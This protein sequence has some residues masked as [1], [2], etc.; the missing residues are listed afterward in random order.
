MIR[1]AGTVRIASLSRLRE[2]VAAQRPGEGSSPSGSR[3]TRR[4]FSLLEI[5]VSTL[6]AGGVLVVALR[7]VG[8]AASSERVN[9]ER[10]RATP[11]AGALMAEVL[12]ANYREPKPPRVF[13]P[14]PGETASG[15]RALFDD[16]DDYHGWTESPPQNKDGAVLPGLIGWRRSVTVQYVS[17]DNLATAAAGDLGVKRVTVTVTR[18]GRPVFSL[19]MALTRSWRQPPYD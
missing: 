2:R 4:G 15:T 13:G 14:E 19:A 18:D 7:A 16:V 6:I 3:S 17:P 11:L 8:S 5:S 9:A 12:E 10:A 1:H